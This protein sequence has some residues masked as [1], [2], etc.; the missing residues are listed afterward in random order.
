MELTLQKK[1]QGGFEDDT[2]PGA[3]MVPKQ[4][5]IEISVRPLR[6]FFSLYL[7]GLCLESFFSSA[8]EGLFG[9]ISVL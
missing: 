1:T 9:Q 6:T 7:I 3:K 5:L 4:F 2:T 8:V